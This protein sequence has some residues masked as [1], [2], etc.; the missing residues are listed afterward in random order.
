MKSRHSLLMSFRWASAGIVQA[1]RNDRN[2]RIEVLI[3]A[4][5]VIAGLWLQ[6]PREHWAILTLTIAV[7]LAG[8]M[9]NSAVEALTDLISPEVHSLA[10]AAKDIAAGAVLVLSAASV[11][12]G[13]VILGPPLFSALTAAAGG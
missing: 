6:I 13:L 4:C 12:V 10:K 9:M 2:L 3:A 1:L 8:E 7:V 5:V 11:V